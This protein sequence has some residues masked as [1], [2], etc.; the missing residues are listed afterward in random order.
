MA[1]IPQRAVAF[2]VAGDE[3]HEPSDREA[4]TRALAALD[5]EF[6]YL[7]PLQSLEGHGWSP[8]WAGWKYVIV[9][10]AHIGPARALASASA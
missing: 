5:E 8:G 6:G 3:D 2:V 4:A 7:P 1:M 9:V 10:D